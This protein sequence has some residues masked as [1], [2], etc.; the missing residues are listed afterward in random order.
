MFFTMPCPQ[1][2][3]SLKGR[4]DLIGKT[5]RCPYCRAS[6]T[7]QRPAAAPPSPAEATTSDEFAFEAKP[8]ATA[9]SPAATGRTTTRSAKSSR[10]PAGDAQSRG[11]PRERPQPGQAGPPPASEATF[12]A[13]PDTNVNGFWA[14]LGAVAATACFYA[15]LWPLSTIG[16]KQTYLGRLFIGTSSL[17]AGGWVP[18]VEVF[19]FCW[20]SGMLIQKWL[21]IRRQQRGL[22]YDVLPMELGDTITLGNLDRFVSQI[23]SLPEEAAGSFLVTRCLRGLEHFRVRKSAADTA[24][25]LAS[26]SDIDASNVD[27]SYT[28]FH[29]FIWAIPILGFLGTVIGVSSA[30]G[31]FTGTLESSNDIGA[32]KE[33]LKS[34]TSGLGTAFDTTL[35]ALSMAMILTF[36]VSWLQKYEGDI[37][38]QVDEYTNENF[39]RRLDDGREG[40][41]ERGTGGTR[42][43][44]AQAIE[45]ALAPHQA[46]LE[47]WTEQVRSIGDDVAAQVKRGWDE[48]TATLV[49]EH[50]RQAG[51]VEEI[52]GLVTA[53]REGLAR[54]VADAAA[55][56][57]EAGTSLKESAASL[58]SYTAA[59]ERGLAALAT[60]LE[61]LGEEKI[62]VEVRPKSR[63][64]L[65]GG[66]RR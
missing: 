52:D 32:L 13:A 65:F 11:Q 37:L 25:M 18:I 51:R 49:D 48:V 31:G 56:R 9:G 22:L 17:S 40:G 15:I 55:A 61:K 57:R 66:R 60:T 54:V 30:V 23:R 6:V 8:A 42:S 21:K 47:A 5:A 28:M 35:V 33:G 46:R 12:A 64:S 19:L 16:D 27:S 53:S 63:W 41:A 14:L 44:L 4:D 58:H 50:A 62:V 45:Q 43:E 10:P 24:T 7:V 26:Q 38:G 2:G 39:L 36:P 59:L 29:V 34:I 3:K 1:C 20:A